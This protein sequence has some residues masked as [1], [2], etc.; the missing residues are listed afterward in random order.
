MKRICSDL[1]KQ[2]TRLQK[3]EMCTDFAFLFDE[4]EPSKE[5]SL[6]DIKNFIESH[7]GE[8][9]SEDLR[10]R[11]LINIPLAITI[12]EWLDTIKNPDTRK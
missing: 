2:V 9:S 8:L 1:K 7:K 3:E 12:K 11:V 4:I 10:R 5:L 6:K